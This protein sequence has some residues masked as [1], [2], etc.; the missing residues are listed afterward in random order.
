MKRNSFFIVFWV[1]NFVCTLRGMTGGRNGWELIFYHCLLFLYTLL[2]R[3]KEG[4]GLESDLGS[5]WE[6]EKL[7]L[8]ERQLS[9]IEWTW[10][11]LEMDF[12]EFLPHS[13]RL[14][15]WFRFLRHFR[16]ASFLPNLYSH[17]HF[18]P[19][20]IADLYLLSLRSHSSVS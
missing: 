10:Y 6:R 18:T 17:S 14:L 4:R 19:V 13:G 9:E 8:L 15:V 20:R 3:L 7:V 5:C 16:L 1:S 11:R 2:L 12:A